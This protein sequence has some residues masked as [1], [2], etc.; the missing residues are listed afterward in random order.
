[1]TRFALPGKCGFFGAS[2]FGAAPGVSAC[3]GDANASDPRP[4]DESRRKVRRVRCW[5]WENRG[6]IAAVLPSAPT[7]RS[8]IARGGSPWVITPHILSL[9]P[10]RGGAS[11]RRPVGA[12]GIC[13]DADRFQGLPPLAIVGRP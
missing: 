7:G 2:G 12:G 13:P 4:I 6:S 1:M 11:K 9:P 3:R 10:Q 8:I 5:R